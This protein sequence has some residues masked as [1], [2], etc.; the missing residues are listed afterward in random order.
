[1]SQDRAEAPVERNAGGHGQ[2]PCTGGEWAVAT[3]EL[4]VLRDQ[5]DEP[6][7]RE[8]GDRDRA[9]GRTEPAVLEQ[10]HVQHRV[11]GAPLLPDERGQEGPSD[12]EPTQ[13]GG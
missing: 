3:D 8:E 5:E 12:R 13:G 7:K 11:R 2:D 6:C 9:A 10:G 1:M 4:E